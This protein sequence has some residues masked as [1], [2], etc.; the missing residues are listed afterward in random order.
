M[1]LQVRVACVDGGW[2]AVSYEVDETLP[3]IGFKVR[4]AAA[5]PFSRRRRRHLATKRTLPLC[6]RRR[7][8]WTAT[9]PSRRLRSCVSSSRAARS[10]T[11]GPSER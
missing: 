10:A 7:S 2:E 3:L 5:G 4:V 11:M 9:R 1:I 6:A 8:W